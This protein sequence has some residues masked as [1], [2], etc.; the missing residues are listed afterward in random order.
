MLVLDIPLF[1]AAK[2]VTLSSDALSLVSSSPG[3]SLGE[4][5]TCGGFGGGGGSDGGGTAGGY[6][7]GVCPM[8]PAGVGGG[9]AG[10]AGTGAGVLGV[11][12]VGGGGLVRS[13]RLRAGGSPGLYAGL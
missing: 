13:G 11:L 9:G 10:N 3:S 5:I 2:G 7:V 1:L 8:I 12:G 4:G 6:P